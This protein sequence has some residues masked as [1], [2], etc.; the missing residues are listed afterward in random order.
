M[1]VTIFNVWHIRVCH[2]PCGYM[3]HGACIFYF[4]FSSFKPHFSMTAFYGSKDCMEEFLNL[5]SSIL[6]VLSQLN[7]C[8][9]K[10]LWHIL[11][12]QLSYG[13]LKHGA[14]LFIFQLLLL[15]DQ[16]F[17]WNSFCLSTRCLAEVAVCSPL[18]LIAWIV[19]PQMSCCTSFLK[20]F[21]VQLFSSGSYK[22][23]HKI[24]FWLIRF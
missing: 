5:I 11:V 16:E 2:T 9:T 6:L 8:I 19:L 4:S 7:L 20:L 1:V 3:K 12:W 13:S 23:I 22:L 10:P 15:M 21:N 17:I 14:W 18:S 24:D